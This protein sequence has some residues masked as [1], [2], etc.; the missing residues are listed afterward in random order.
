MAFE[1][2]EGREGGGGGGGG[3]HGPGSQPHAIQVI[4]KAYM[5]YLLPEWHSFMDLSG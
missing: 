4:N 5:L 2:E 3:M 1:L